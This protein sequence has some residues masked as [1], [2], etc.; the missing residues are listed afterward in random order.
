MSQPMISD[1]VWEQLRD[2]MPPPAHTGRPRYDDRAI[3]EGILYQAAHSCRWRDIPAVY[4]HHV[5]I[6][7]RA[8]S[9]SQDGSLERILDRLGL[10]TTPPGGG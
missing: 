4:G 6:W 1:E 3:L 8:R 5:T 2:L 10:A 7:R 9:W